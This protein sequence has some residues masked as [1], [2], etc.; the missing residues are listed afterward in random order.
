MKRVVLVLAAV[1]LVAIVKLIRMMVAPKRDWLLKQYRE[2]YHRQR[3]PICGDP[4]RR[5]PLRHARWTRKGPVEPV[6]SE[7][8]EREV[9]D[10][11]YACPACGTRLFEPCAECK[12]TR[13][14][15]LPYCGS[16]GCEKPVEGAPEAS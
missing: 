5:G 12:A 1:V 6:L 4:I 7:R 8:G 16:C 9:D 14:S 10:P 11:P 13:H 15:L 2:A 3:C